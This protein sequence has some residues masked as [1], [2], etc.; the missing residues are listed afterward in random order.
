MNNVKDQIKGKIAVPQL[1]E[2]AN[3]INDL[4]GK[5]EQSIGEEI[6]RILQDLSDLGFYSDLSI[7]ANFEK[8]RKAV[9]DKIDDLDSTHYDLI[10]TELKIRQAIRP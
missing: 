5:G 3:L 9:S 8:A 1:D 4:L 10:Q 2:L 6:K 7:P